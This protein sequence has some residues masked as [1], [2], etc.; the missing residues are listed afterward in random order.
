L[1]PIQHLIKQDL[2]ALKAGLVPLEKLVV[3][4][5]VSRTLDEFKSKSSATYAAL[6]QLSL[7]GKVLE[8]GQYV[9]L[10]YTRGFPCARAWDIPN[11]LDKRSVD[12]P[13]YQR[14]YLRAVNTVLEPVIGDAV[15]VETA[16]QL[17]LD[18]ENGTCN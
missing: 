7:Q 4:Q 5:K 10:I 2:Q 1:E 13:R 11:E 16:K 8:P 6:Q 12:Y 17:Y 18:F 14:L 3:H 9:R 15:T